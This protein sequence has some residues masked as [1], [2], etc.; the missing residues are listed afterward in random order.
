[1]S[2]GQDDLA[3]KPL[4]PAEV[5]WLWWFGSASLLT[6][7][8]FAVGETVFGPT[9]VYLADRIGHDPAEL[10]FLW[11]VAGLAWMAA[12]VASSAVFKRFIRTPRMK[13]NVHYILF[14]LRKV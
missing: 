9:H 6:H 5:K 4:T 13:V 8:S 12:A 10:S 3:V 2:P 11:T 1:M 14:I 7:F